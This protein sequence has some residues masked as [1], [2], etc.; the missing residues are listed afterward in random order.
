MLINLH[1]HH[2]ST[3]SKHTVLDVYN[4]YP[5]DFVAHDSY[6][7]IGIHP[8]FILQ[9]NIPHDLD[10]IQ[11]H[12]N[13]PQCLAIGEIG[14]D[15]LCNID[16][17]LQVEIFKQQLAIA[18]HHQIPVILHCVRAYQEILM[19]RKQ[20][21]LTIPFIFHGFN[22]NLNLAQQ[23]TTNR[24]ILS[25]GKNLLYNTNLQS[26]FAGLSD[27]EFFLENDGSE[28]PIEEIYQKAAE[29]RGTTVEDIEQVVLSNFESVFKLRLNK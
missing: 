26:I 15:K 3:N 9:S 16:F 10:V 7:S 2:L 29:V 19:I 14:L 23:I 12:L 28:I 27:D 20:M 24:C 25:F 6:Y 4:Q 17:N 11:H 21:Q 18:E 22:K 5:W 8:V 13:N 1:T